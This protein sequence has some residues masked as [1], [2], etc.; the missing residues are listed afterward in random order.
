MKHS[1][2]VSPP[3]VLVLI[4]FNQELRVTSRSIGHVTS[5]LWG[6]NTAIIIFKINSMRISYQ[7]KVFGIGAFHFSVQLSYCETAGF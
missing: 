5:T 4:F 2:Q 7:A 1:G 3:D 6:N